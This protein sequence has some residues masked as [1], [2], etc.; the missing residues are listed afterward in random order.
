MT[1]ETSEP[2]VE[3]AKPFIYTAIANKDITRGGYTITQG[4]VIDNKDI[5]G[6]GYTIKQG[7]VIDQTKLNEDLPEDL[8]KSRSIAKGAYL[9]SY[10]PEDFDIV[11]SVS[12]DP[13]VMSQYLQESGMGELSDISYSAPRI[14]HNMI[15]GESN[16]IK[17]ALA[18]VGDVSS[19]SGRVLGSVLGNIGED[20]YFEKVR[21][22]IGRIDGS[23]SDSWY[24]QLGQDIIRDPM[25]IPS[26][27]TG[28]TAMRLAPKFIP[29]SKGLIASDMIMN[30]II[31]TGSKIGLGTTAGIAD[32]AGR[33]LM[34]DY[35]QSKN[36]IGMQDYALGA[37]G[38]SVMPFVVKGSEKL[39]TKLGD[40]ANLVKK[41][42]PDIPKV[43]NLNFTR[44]SDLMENI[45]VRNPEGNLEVI[46]NEAI[47]KGVTPDYAKRFLSTEFANSNNKFGKL[48]NATDD[49]LIANEHLINNE[50]G[51]LNKMTGG[52][53][54]VSYVPRKA[55][56]LTAGQALSDMLNVAKIPLKTSAFRL[57]NDVN[58]LGNLIE[59]F[60]NADSIAK[61]ENILKDL[62][63]QFKE[64]SK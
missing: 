27:A 50:V 18:G 53:N 19:A 23:K 7:D 4:D 63:K 30:P 45:N 43:P 5:T 16:P 15:S 35:S 32:V 46:L 64:K 12:D 11:K 51:A 37:L 8:V 60:R 42:I 6:G 56:Q 38:G 25:L 40:L 20:N 34:N 55:I 36:N 14:A 1:K 22:D 41:P 49:Y 17:N 29:G 44:Q 9:A 54:Y 26:V 3:S 24:G 21:N 62:K 31:N 28:S 47:N 59:D 39:A 2:I 57:P 52:L 61:K 33:D 58:A 10:N 48:G 13:K